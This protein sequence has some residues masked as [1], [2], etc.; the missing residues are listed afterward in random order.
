MKNFDEGTDALLND[1]LAGLAT[2]DT[3]HAW[4]A[5]EAEADVTPTSVLADLTQVGTTVVAAGTLASASRIIDLGELD[6]SAETSG[7]VK[8][9][10]VSTDDPGNAGAKILA[11]QDLDGGSAIDL[12]T[13]SGLIVDDLSIEVGYLASGS[14]G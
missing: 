13:A 10:V 5:A 7:S 9:V 4:L 14:I 3:L 6:F 8:S 12:A 2:A 1:G 11:I